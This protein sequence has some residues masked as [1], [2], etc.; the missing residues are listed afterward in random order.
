[1]KER[2]Q[3]WE[4]G[5][6]SAEAEVVGGNEEESSAAGDWACSWMEPISNKRKKT[7]RNMGGS[8]I[9]RVYYDLVVFRVKPRIVPK[10]D[11]QQAVK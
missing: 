5:A 9:D 6:V 1:M 10:S 11:F 3:E 8:F 2:G 7:R 4:L